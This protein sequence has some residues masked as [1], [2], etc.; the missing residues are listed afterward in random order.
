[1]VV[2]AMRVLIKLLLFIQLG[3]EGQANALHL[4]HKILGVT[5]P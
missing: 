1:M 4:I 5:S 3:V 2:L